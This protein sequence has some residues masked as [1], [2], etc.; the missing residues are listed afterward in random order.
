M[1]H[2]TLRSNFSNQEVF[3]LV[4]Q[5]KTKFFN[6]WPKIN[7]LTESFNFFEG[8]KRV[9]V[10]MTTP[11]VCPTGLGVIFTWVWLG[12]LPVWI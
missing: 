11:R 9:S 12:V 8:G 4:T 1:L 2:L 6:I 5:V 7:T 3:P 10:Q